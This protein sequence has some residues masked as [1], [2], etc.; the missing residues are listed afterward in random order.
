MN[1][2]SRATVFDLLPR[3]ILKQLAPARL[4][5]GTLSSYLPLL[6]S[7]PDGVQQFQVAQDP[8]FIATYSS[9]PQKRD[10]SK[11]YSAPL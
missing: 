11:R 4:S 8:A 9:Q 1:K 5:C 6:P 7:G 2:K 10:A 3:A